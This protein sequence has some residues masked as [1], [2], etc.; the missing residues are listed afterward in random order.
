MQFE[1]GMSVRILSEGKTVYEG[2][3]F[4]AYP[5]CR[6]EPAEIV[7]MDT[8]NKTTKFVEQ[9]E[10]WKVTSVYIKSNLRINNIYQI[11][12]IAT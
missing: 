8:D 12:P 11:E 7:F 2:S 4:K 9:D 1:T 5:R 3:I 6:H 10:G